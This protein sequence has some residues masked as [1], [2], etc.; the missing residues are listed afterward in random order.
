MKIGM[1][2][3]YCAGR[4]VYVENRA[5]DEE[6][7]AQHE[8]GEPERDPPPGIPLCVQERLERRLRHADDDDERGDRSCR[9]QIV[10]AAELAPA[11]ERIPKAEPLD[12]RGRNG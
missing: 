9:V 10:R 7:W 5:A 1:A 3:A 4:L 2:G 11:R 6:Q 8:V 12:H